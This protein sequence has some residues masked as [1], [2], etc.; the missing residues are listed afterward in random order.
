MAIIVDQIINIFG[1]IIQLR[2]DHHP[3]PPLISSPFNS[4]DFS[5]NYYFN[6]KTKE[7]FSS[8][9]FYISRS[10]DFAVNE[11]FPGPI[12]LIDLI[13]LNTLFHLGLVVIILLKPASEVDYLIILSYKALTQ[14]NL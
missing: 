3:I 9:Y 8:L 5:L 7:L 1:L 10:F 11:K 13:G 4:F 2:Y 14:R 12:F 6:S